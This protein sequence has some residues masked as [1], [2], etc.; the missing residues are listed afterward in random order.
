MAEWLVSVC[1]GQWQLEAI[2]I[3]R[4][5]G[6]EVLALDGD[7]AAPGLAEA[8][9]A[10]V[11]DISDPEAVVDAVRR[12]GVRPS[13]VVSVVAEAGQ[14]S[15][16]AVRE[17][18]QLPGATVET[19]RALTD[20]GVQRRLWSAAELPCPSW[21]LAQSADGVVEAVSELGGETIVKPVDSAGSRGITRLSGEHDDPGAAAMRALSASR[22][23]TAIVERFV[24][25]TEF[26]VET[27]GCAGQHH[28]LAVTSKRKVPGSGDTV[29]MEL[30]T[31]D[32]PEVVIE[33][34]ADLAARALSAL[35]Y[36]DGP[37]HTE[38]LRSDDGALTL[39]EA[40]GRGGGFMVAQ[41]L[42]PVVS[43]VDLLQQTVRLAVG[44]EAHGAPDQRRP[45]V[46]RFFPSSPGIVRAIEGFPAARS[47][48]GVEAGAFV[49]VGDRVGGPC[50]DG[51]RLGYILATG[52]STAE[53]RTRADEAAALVAFEI[54]EESCA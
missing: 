13:G 42:V 36:V 26:A 22:S 23:G 45:V 29:A 6:L 41:R 27:L 48:P 31:P 11:V 30:S 25:G 20:K 54:E 14:R 10:A 2:R 34:V 40:A 53:A 4:R 43:G 16:A 24:V 39:V 15:A 32:L 38:I 5:L 49:A 52:A 44:R 7:A 3:A 51:D 28:V 9:R 37:G 46:L 18:F 50:T 35:G 19:T 33:E 1:A 17:A 21:R 8:D 47:V 12:A